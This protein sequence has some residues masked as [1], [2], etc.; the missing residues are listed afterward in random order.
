MANTHLPRV[1]FLCFFVASLI[2]S[3]GV[4][5]QVVETAGMGL[6]AEA[7]EWPPA[8][9]L[10]DGEIGQ[11]DGDSDLGRRRSLLWHTM[12]LYISYGAL[13][14]SR[15]PCPPRSGRSYYTPDCHKAQGPVHPY[16]R[17]CSAIT[18]CRR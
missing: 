14:A 15:I 4:G 16:S 8:M 7:L 17:G 1:F 11:E 2:E 3:S 12:R 13:A 6:M 5:A 9:S 10:F 18:R